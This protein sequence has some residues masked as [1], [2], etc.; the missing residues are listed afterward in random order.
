[1]SDYE[2]EFDAEQ[3]EPMHIREI[4]PAGWQQAMIIESETVDTKRKMA[5]EC[6]LGRVLKLTWQIVGGE[7]DGRRVFDTVNRENDNPE[8]VA[9]G[10]AQ[11]SS[12]CR[13]SG[14]LKIPTSAT[15]HKIIC[16]IKIA[17]Q[18]AKN[19]YEARNVIKGY[20]PAGESK[21]AGQQGTVAP[22]APPV[23]TTSPPAGK[24][25]WMKK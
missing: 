3:Y 22:T 20:L 23:P 21:A 10:N 11:L 6:R 16:D 19:G 25:P 8:A 17:V 9:I 7:H 13:A 2:Q 24:A 14:R 1:M 12:I 15:L 4:L 5:G 18:A